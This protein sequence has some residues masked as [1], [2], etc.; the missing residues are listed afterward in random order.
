MPNLIPPVTATEIS[1]LA[2][3]TRATVS[4]WRKRHDDFPKPI[5]GTDFRP[6]FDWNAVQA[7]LAERGQDAA[8]TPLLTL[9]TQLR[10]TLSSADAQALITQLTPT[11]TG[12]ASAEHRTTAA[13]SGVLRTLAEVAESEGPRAALQTLADH[14][15]GG[16]QNVGLYRTPEPVA[17]LMADLLRPLGAGLVRVLDPACGSGSLLIAAAATGATELYGQDIAENQAA[18]A[19]LAVPAETDIEPDIAVGDSLHSDAFP[20]LSA[21]AVLCSPLSGRDWGADR[22]RIDD[23]RWIFGVPRRTDSEFAWIQ[24][25][26]AHLRPG[27]FAVLLLPALAASQPS[28]RRIRAALLR[29]GA[30]RAV[31]ALPPR[32]PQLLWTRLTLQLWIMAKPDPDAP[33]PDAVLLVD[34]AGSETAQ[35]AAGEALDWP[36]I[37][38]TVRR[39]WSA[40]AAGRQAEAEEPGVATV[41]RVVDLL[42]EEVDLAPGP[43]VRLAIDPGVVAREADAALARLR[44]AIADLTAA[45]ESVGRLTGVPGATWR[46]ATV[47]DLASGGAIRVLRTPSKAAG[48][49]DGALRPALTGRDIATGAP[50]SGA[51][52]ADAATPAIDIEVDDIL[53]PTARTARGPAFRIAGP[54]EAGL[55][56]GPHAQIVRTDPQRFDPWFVAGFLGGL[57]DIAATG[58]TGIHSA[59]HRTRIPLLPPAE[60]RRYGAAFR[61]VHHLRATLTSAGAAVDHI[62]ETVTTGLVAGALAPAADNTNKNANNSRGGSE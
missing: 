24:H 62:T 56:L 1:Q 53:V 34:T 20:E 40:F 38:D 55:A 33:P 5:G 46:T 58:T 8:D 19:R 49:D 12:W 6:L 50:A 13:V 52:R 45:A 35:S 29:A 11:G 47:S 3:V 2:G 41:V 25:A 43:R 59:L 32:L 7:W 15:N 14:A 21:D 61:D 39:V 17:T 23:P 60:Q 30:L 37:A 31:I 4:N 16:E 54:A 48:A 51:V 27:G 44:T 26:L 36:P 42:D 9:R 10:S 57:D 28:A 22:A 18:L